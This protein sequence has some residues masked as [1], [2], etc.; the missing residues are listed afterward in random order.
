MCAT[1]RAQ[2]AKEVRA[3]IAQEVR[4]EVV[5][6][7]EELRDELT[8]SEVWSVKRATWTMAILA[9]QGKLTRRAR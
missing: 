1:E 6:E 5:A 9:A 3:Q 8:D 7:L 2:I 4:A